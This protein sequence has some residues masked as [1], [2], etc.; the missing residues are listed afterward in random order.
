MGPTWLQDPCVGPTTAFRPFLST[1]SIRIDLGESVSAHKAHLLT[2]QSSVLFVLKK[3]PAKTELSTFYR[4]IH[5]AYASLLISN[6]R[7][8]QEIVSEFFL[9]ILLIHRFELNEK[10]CAFLWGIGGT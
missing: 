8:L 5:F 3:A 9:G 1:A 2:P 10:S 4:R 7:R 6:L